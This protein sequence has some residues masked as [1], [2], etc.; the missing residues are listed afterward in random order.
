M[1][2]FHPGVVADTMSILELALAGQEW[3]SEATGDAAWTAALFPVTH[4]YPNVMHALAVQEWQ[5]QVE[6]AGNSAGA[7]MMP[8]IRC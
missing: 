2:D 7:G 6:A 1:L 8:R 5:L 3:Q 4:T